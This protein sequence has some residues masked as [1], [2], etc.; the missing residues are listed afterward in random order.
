MTEFIKTTDSFYQDL[1]SHTE[2]MEHA[3]SRSKYRDDIECMQKALQHNYPEGKYRVITGEQ[4]YGALGTPKVL[5]K[6]IL[7]T[8][9]TKHHPDVVS[10][11]LF[12]NLDL[13]GSEKGFYQLSIP[14][15]GSP[16]GVLGYNLL[17]ERIRSDDSIAA[18]IQ[19]PNDYITRQ[20]A[21]AL[22]SFRGYYPGQMPHGRGPRYDIDV[23]SNWARLYGVPEKTSVNQLG[24][25]AEAHIQWLTNLEHT[26]GIKL[27]YLARESEVDLLLAKN[28]GIN[29]LDKTWKRGIRRLRE[30]GYTPVGIKITEDQDEITPFNL[31]YNGIRLRSRFVNNDGSRILL[32][33]PKDPSS[34]HEITIDD[35]ISGKY[36]FSFRA[37][38]RV[39]L[40]S[41]AAL[42]GHITGGGSIYN[43]D[44]RYFMELEGMP[45]FPITNMHAEENGEKLS[46]IQYIS[47]ALSRSNHPGAEEA[48]RKGHLSLLDFVLSC[49]LT[50]AREC[51][52]NTID[53]NQPFKTSQYIVV[54]NKE[55][56][57]PNIS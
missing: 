29:I 52:A 6:R 48:L 19:L 12:A 17:S 3:V 39:L 1:V 36:G 10:I 56:A 54:P 46:C 45:Y 28:G 16:D 5:G 24:N 35:A 21:K 7:A 30:I 34:S 37:V 2:D 18:G 40:Y 53:K 41:L 20:I 47:L 42:S 22:Q 43:Q 25:Y 4:P 13:V 49:N 23:M 44:A 57:I 38:P 11:E 26:L 31:S 32:S 55:G 33:N 15:I 27:D 50:E 14:N 9:L 51:I 8:A